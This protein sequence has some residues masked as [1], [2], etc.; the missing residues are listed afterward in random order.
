MLAH[1]LWLRKSHKPN[2]AT[3]GPGPSAC[4]L[5]GPVLQGTPAS[6]AAL[7]DLP[8]DSPRPGIF[9]VQTVW[10]L[11]SDF[12]ADCGHDVFSISF[13][14]VDSP[15]VWHGTCCF[16]MRGQWKTV[17]T[18][19]FCSSWMWHISRASSGGNTAKKTSPFF[20]DSPLQHIYKSMW[21]E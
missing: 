20:D 6:P 19:G 13:F 3:A 14:G 8:S 16:S 10:I 5:L 11:T 2:P 21:F 1:P 4:C 12:G 9:C 17:F 18:I 7:A 15:K